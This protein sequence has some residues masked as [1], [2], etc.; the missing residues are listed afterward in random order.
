MQDAKILIDKIQEDTDI[1]IKGILGQAE[2]DADTILQNAREIASDIW[3]E[4]RKKAEK[5]SEEERKRIISNSMLENKKSV[6]EAKQESITKAFKLAAKKIKQMDD[7]K[8]EKFLASL[9]IKMIAGKSAKIFVA[10]NDR[11]RLSSKFIDNINEEIKN[12]GGNAVVSFSDVDFDINEGVVIS[13]GRYQIDVS[14]DS[15]IDM[16]RDDL[17]TEIVNILFK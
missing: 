17:E 16:Q 6:L 13:Q 5:D 4:M 14:L 1:K 2:Q 3:N 15:M 8:Y 12:K 7:N 9:V 11:S 10:Y